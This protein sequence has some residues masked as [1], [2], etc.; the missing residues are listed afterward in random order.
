MEQTSLDTL[1]GED[2]QVRSNDDRDR[3]EDGSSDFV[4][5]LADA[6][7]RRLIGFPAMA[8]VADDVL[9]HDDR[10]IHNHA[11]IQRAKGQQVC[12]NAFQLEQRRIFGACETTGIFFP[13]SGVPPLVMIWVLAI[14]C[15]F[16][17][18]PTSRIL[19]CCRPAS[20]KLPPALAL[21][22]VSCCSTWARLSPYAISLLGSTRT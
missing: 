20:M 12:W 7:H 21:L 15:T 17:T 11:E 5:R 16:R 4:R 18:R 10:A 9:H 8:H 14:S 19:I 3:V 22:L 13:R 6:L 2:G 1:Q